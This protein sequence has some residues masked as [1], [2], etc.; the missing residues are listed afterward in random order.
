MQLQNKDVRENTIRDLQN[1]P[2]IVK[3]GMGKKDIAY[4][5]GQDGK[6]STTPMDL[7]NEIK[8]AESDALK[9]CARGLGIALDL[10]SGEDKED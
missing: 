8:A 7:G 10:Y 4:Q 6:I 1:Q 5:K 2:R 3:M 9:R